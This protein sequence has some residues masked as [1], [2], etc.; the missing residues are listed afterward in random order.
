MS[1]IP[2]RTGIAASTHKE[3]PEAKNQPP[4]WPWMTSPP[5]DGVA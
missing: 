4:H 5:D 2:V 3:F 1:S